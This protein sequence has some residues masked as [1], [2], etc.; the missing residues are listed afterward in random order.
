MGLGPDTRKPELIVQPTPL[1][2]AQTAP[3]GY[4][5]VKLACGAH[6]IHSLAHAETFHPVIGPVAE[7][8]ALYIR[9]LRLLERISRHSGDFVV[10]DVGLGAAANSITLLRATSPL[11]CSLQLISFDNT[12]DP[13]RFAL[14]HTDNLSY[15]LGYEERLGRLLEE[16]A[17]KFKDEDHSVRWELHLSDFPG[18]LKEP[19]ARTFAQPHAIMFDAFSPAKNPEMWTLPLFTNLFGLLDP[20]RPCAL[21]TYSRS[22]MLRVT[23]LL[24]GFFVGVGHATGEKEETTIAANCLELIDE[25]LDRRW[26]QRARKSTSAEPMHEPVYRQVPL[27]AES[28]ERLQRHPQFAA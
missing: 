22:T 14:Q 19:V 17:L 20:G 9:Q 18:L 5:V 16:R 13:L 25:P 26:L 21:P 3:A 24:A 2:D 11:S 10:W 4:R 1:N 8:E 15:L 23:L 6:S 27:S 12:V 7:A 28:W